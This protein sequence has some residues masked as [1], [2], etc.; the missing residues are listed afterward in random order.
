MNYRTLV[1]VVLAALL[2]LSSLPHALASEGRAE[3]SIDTLREQIRGLEAAARDSSATPEV[4]SLNAEFLNEKRRELVRLLA[5]RSAALRAYLA[6]A[7][8]ALNER[9]GERVRQAI[10]KLD[11]E[12]ASLQAARPGAGAAAATAATRPAGE[13]RYANA[14]ANAEAAARNLPAAS[15]QEESR[16]T[17]EKKQRAFDACNRCKS[18]EGS[19]MIDAR[20]NV[21]AEQVMMGETRTKV[22]RK[23]YRKGDRVNVSVYNMNPFLYKYTV[24]VEGR[25]VIET[26][27]LEFLEKLGGPLVGDLDG[28]TT[29][30]EVGG[31]GAGSPVMLLREA[32][33]A[34]ADARRACT[35]DAG[36]A[37]EYVASVQQKVAKAEEKLDADFAYL[38]KKHKA[39][40]AQYTATRRALYDPLADCVELC[41]ASAEYTVY[42]EENPL[43]TMIEEVEAQIDN[44]LEL[45]AELGVALAQ[46][47]Q[48]N[49]AQGAQ[50]KVKLR[51]FDYA[52]SLA[53]YKTRVDLNATAYGNKLVEWNNDNERR[54]ERLDARIASV[55]NHPDQ[56]LR[57][58]FLIGQYETATDVTITLAWQRLP[59][60]LPF[61]GDFK[62]NGNGNGSGNG[63]D[64]GT[65]TASRSGARNARPAGGPA[66]TDESSAVEAQ[67]LFTVSTKKTDLNFGG[68]PRFALSAGLVYSPF[69]SQK[70]GMVKGFERDAAGNI[71]GE[72][73]E[74]TDVV[75]VT[76]ESES[77]VGPLLMLSTRMTEFRDNNIFFS[78]GIT[79]TRESGNTDVEYLVGPSIN[80]FDRRLFLTAG[81]Y[82]GRQNVLA[83]DTHLGAK[84]TSDTNIT[85]K[86]FRWRPGFSLTYRIK[87]GDEDPPPAQ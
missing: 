39:A 12:V 8:T 70:F 71:V 25:P 59:D 42:M 17:L 83:G 54:Y 49:Q 64:G 76:D 19:F 24:L 77:R 36:E 82:A 9:E 20:A 32:G 55:I 73:P 41:R 21:A 2:S 13:V 60:E 74:L 34:A 27:H 7:G 86:E 31:Q 15:A 29:T 56:T 79:A 14:W 80:L 40:E 1:S 11:A 75:G 26:E 81:G 62:E 84:I 52:S 38:R 18:P 5:S 23:R 22:Q 51:G 16:L 30:R 63:G 53:S 48:I 72:A 43:G 67:R 33:A 44:I 85:R 10:E 69:R 87:F 47:N 37:L 3:V 35:G 4:E 68:G 66:A 61:E 45:T 50:C 6:S 65:D 58:E 78:L 57:Q 46:F 28:K